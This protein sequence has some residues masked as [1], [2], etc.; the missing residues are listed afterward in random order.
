M[1][2][3]IT[4]INN[5]INDIYHLNYVRNSNNQ[6]YINLYVNNLYNKELWGLNNYSLI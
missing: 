5:F 4:I 2:N 6:V 1:Q 3:I